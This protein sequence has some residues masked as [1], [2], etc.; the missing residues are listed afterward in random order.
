MP[1]V[2]KTREIEAWLIDYLAQELEIEP[3]A[4][5]I[6]VPFERYGLDSSAAII[7]TGD[8]E[9]WLTCELEPELLFDYQS[10]AELTQYI[11][12]SGL[13]DSV[14]PNPQETEKIK[15][16]PISHQPDTTSVYPLSHGQRALWFTYQMA[17]ESA[18]AYN[19]A[20]TARIRSQVNVPSLQRAFQALIARHPMLR[21]TFV[22][23]D[24][25]PVQQ[26]NTAQEVCF[27][28]IDASNWNWDEL[29]QQ[30]VEAYQCSFD[31]KL[32]P[33]VRM[34]LFN[35]SE[36]DR[37]LL[38]TIDHIICDGWSFWMIMDELR[39]LYSAEENEV[40]LS[41]PPL[42][43][44]YQDYVSWQE[45]MLA[46]SEGKRLWNYWQEQL[47]G[48]LPLLN[49]PTDRPRPPVQTYNGASH[50]FKLTKELTQKL[51]ELAHAEKA[52]LYMTLLAAFQVLLYRYTGQEDILVGS[53]TRGRNHKEFAE[54]LGYF[55]NPV[56]LRADFSDNLTFKEFLAQVRHTVLN[57]FTNQDYPFSLL[58]ERLEP[59]RD[60]SRSPLYQVNFVLQKPQQ[61]VDV[62]IVELLAAGETGVCVDWG[63][64][65]LEPF[66]MA[67]YEGLF[68]LNL[69]MVEARESI[70]GAFKYNKDLFDAST[71]ERM[72]GH[73]Q[74]LLDAIVANPQKPVSEFPLLTTAEQQ[75]LLIEWNQTQR[76]Y[77]QHKCIHQ[78]FEEQV[79]KTPD[80]VALVYQDLQLT[81]G[82]LNSRANQ[83]AH[84][85]QKQ[86]VAPEV[87]VGICVERSLEMVVGLLGILKA[88]GAYVPLDPSYPQDRLAY[89]LSDAQVPVLLT[90][91][92]LT[93]ELPEHQMSVV[94]LD[95]DWQILSSESKENPATAVKPENLAYI[96]Y[97]SGSTGKPKGVLINHNNVARLLT[98]TSSWFNFN[99]NDVWTLFHSY[100]FDFSVWELWGAL[101]YGGTIVVVP[102]NISRSPE[103]FY[104]LLS[105][106]KVTVLNQ[107]PSAF[108]QIIRVED[109]LKKDPQELSLR[110]VIFGGEALELQSLKPWFERHGDLVPQLVNMY[111]IT[112][113][114]VHVTYRPLTLADL[115]ST[116]S[117]V[118]I[119]IPD[120][121]VYIL[122][123]NQQPVPIGVPGEMYVGGAGLARGY[124]NRPELTAERFI[125]NPFNDQPEARI[126]RSGDLARYLPNGDIEYLGRLDHQVKV[127]GFRIELGEIE[128]ALTQN[129]EVRETIV[130]TRED[131]QGDQRLIAYVVPKLQDKSSTS[132]DSV[133]QS[134]HEQIGQWQ[135]VFNST[136]SQSAPT[137]DSTFNIIGW[138]NSYTGELIPAQE[139]R[140]WLDATVE[141]ILTWEPERVLEIGCGTG[142]VLSR[143]APYCSYY[144]GTD[145][146]KNAIQYV[147]QLLQEVK[148]DWSHVKLYHKPAHDFEGFEPDTFDTVI[149]SSVVQYFPSIDYLLDVLE[150][151]TEVVKPGGIIVVSDVRNLNLLEAFHA[152]VQLYQAP[153]SLSRLALR[154]RV[155]QA[156]G[157]EEELVIDPEFFQALKQHLHKISHVQIQLKQGMHHNELT[158]FR[159][160]V[161][162]HLGKESNSSLKVQW[163]DWRKDN[164]T[165]SDIRRILAQTQ[166]EVLGIKNV[167][168]ARLQ[169]ELELEELLAGENEL[170]NVGEID[171]TLKEIKLNEGIDPE[172]FWDISQDLPYV[173]NISWS[174]S[175]NKGSYDVVCQHH[176]QPFKSHR[177]LPL[178]ETNCLVKSWQDY[179]SNP[180]QGKLSR[181]L[182]PQL[183][184]S[185]QHS[186]PNYMV[187]SAF[188]L[189]E[190]LP[191]TPNGKV[192]RRALPA[193]DIFR[194]EVE[195]ELVAPRTET[196]EILTGIWSEILRVEVGIYDNFFELGGHSL[197]ATQ[198]ISRLREAFS[199]ELSLNIIFANPTIAQLAEQVVRAQLEQAKS[200]EL[201]QILAEVDEL[202]DEEVTQLLSS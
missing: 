167:P 193:P 150:Q 134:N 195:A 34:N 141:R 186:L 43:F 40:G 183:R 69:E 138:N 147:E 51:K 131:H 77:P 188:V 142:M 12:D 83:V 53:P 89:I 184:S 143:I 47:A 75:Q 126:Y 28:E 91:S 166:P 59:N 135:Q 52:T 106:E 97:T 165:I 113:T 62:D 15:A 158:R 174:D 39:G 115:N 42:E 197:L 187:P 102:Y 37:I 128:S 66:E 26:V 19:I 6:T 57:A 48:E 50:S 181:Q 49:L 132:Q 27:E 179:A 120:L 153:D 123:Q 10:I 172:Q 189:L 148:G 8:L 169:V 170:A 161:V 156:M 4:V 88:G 90:H 151:A 20:F 29:K 54:I 25:E 92:S 55:V 130:I 103:E 182:I 1:K 104:D 185:L 112:E 70:V 109:E 73:F 124:L 122:D 168:N 22:E 7:M 5:D 84:Y 198:V 154:Q 44:S 61:S 129:S 173:I 60:S 17:P 114:T 2:S 96:I 98:A 127:R 81:Y 140:E 108:R 110:L 32:G 162:L 133:N 9:D 164:L 79:A 152:S 45:E 71:I 107:T 56:V 202:S 94:C 149:L 157:Q 74:T 72:A 175:D 117:V 180:I 31:L 111:G 116:S 121:Q 101:S 21:T 144:C 118:G 191:L 64:L 38:L 78:L 67:Q 176:D 23:Q 171:K 65:S 14:S 93:T 41:L 30:V 192:D 105:R 11:V 199:I 35:R 24:G 139:M 159:Y 177:M 68:D 178:F 136:Y 145:L 33:L 196:E 85:L 160:D 13:L 76:D 99:E 36:Q 146:S 16:T 163:S 100:A 155:H 63:G 87:L 125:S 95:R 80:A 137:Q 190:A 18:A 201:E 86:G 3:K 46:G 119:P 58:V 194:R 82:E 200:E